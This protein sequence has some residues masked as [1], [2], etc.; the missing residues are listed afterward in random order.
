MNMDFTYGG[1]DLAP[2]TEQGEAISRKNVGG[3][4]V[5]VR[6]DKSRASQRATPNQ[7]M[8][9]PVFKKHHTVA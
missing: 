6:D 5:N 1:P 4:R 2:G 3:S 7:K 8:Y 9:T